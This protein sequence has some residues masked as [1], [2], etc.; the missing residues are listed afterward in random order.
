MPGKPGQTKGTEEATLAKPKGKNVPRL[1]SVKA[2]EQ[3][4]V[5]AGRS[6]QEAE[7][8]L[9]CRPGLLDDRQSRHGQHALDDDFARS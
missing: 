7:T 5:A 2:D 1:D 8:F 6:Y 3:R 4:K 9:G